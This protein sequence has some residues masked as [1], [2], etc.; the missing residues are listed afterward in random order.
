MSSVKLNKYLII[1]KVI[2]FIILSKLNITL[3]SNYDSSGIWYNNGHKN[4]ELAYQKAISEYVY[5]SYQLLYFINN[6]FRQETTKRSMFDIRDQILSGNTEYYLEYEVLRSKGPKRKFNTIRLTKNSVGNQFLKFLDDEP[7]ENTLYFNVIANRYFNFN[8]GVEI[9]CI[10]HIHN[11]NFNKVYC[12]SQ[13]IE[14][15]EL[16]VFK[17]RLPK[18]SLP[19][20]VYNG[21]L[22]K[23]SGQTYPTSTSF[24]DFNNEGVILRNV[25]INHI[26]NNVAKYF[27]WVGTGSSG[28]EGVR[29]ARSYSKLKNDYSRNK[30]YS[31]MTILVKP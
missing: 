17:Y 11:L 7:R 16:Y 18:E 2:F 14:N 30:T 21:D 27:R 31:G 26:Q 9:E 23:V 28:Y 5:N 12:F 24:S 1:F 22:I 8:N 3:A 29:R 6:T 19:A 13:I 20:N 10:L 15:D 25:S 4:G